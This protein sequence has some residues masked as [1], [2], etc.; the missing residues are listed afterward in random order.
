MP[1]CLLGFNAG[2]Y[3]CRPCLRPSGFDAGL[4]MPNSAELM[5]AY[6]SRPRFSILDRRDAVHDFGRH[7]PVLDVWMPLVLP[8]VVLRRLIVIV[9]KSC[10]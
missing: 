1:S 2:L 6:A 3:R 9:L 4:K 10:T 8:A 7:V 5:Y